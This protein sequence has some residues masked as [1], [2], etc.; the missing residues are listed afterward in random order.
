MPAHSTV[1]RLIA[2]LGLALLTSACSVSTAHIGS[3]KVG[4]DHALT[5]QASAFGPHDSIY[6]SA[7]ADNIP[8]KVA[9]QWQL[10]AEN[11]S[12]QPHNSTISQFNKSFDLTS[13]ATTTYDLSPPTAGWPAGTY[14]I[15]VTMLEDG[16]Q[17]DQKTAE[18]TVSGS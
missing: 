14:K 18:F 6:A 13:D 5:T 15:V 2:L 3:F 4:K 17:K 1:P 12:G 16:K 10:V 11:V 8:D 9:L 7:D